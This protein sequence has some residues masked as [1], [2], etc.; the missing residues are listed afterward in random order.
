MHAAAAQ[1]RL[2]QLQYKYQTLVQEIDE[3]GF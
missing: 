1:D 2:M 3:V